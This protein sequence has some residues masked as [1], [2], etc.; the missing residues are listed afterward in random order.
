VSLFEIIRKQLDA[1]VC[2]ANIPY[3]V[4][5]R[6]QGVFEILT[7][8]ALM[9]P[10]FPPF[11]GM[12]KINPSGLP[13]QWS[14]CA[15][16]KLNTVRF[17][18][19]SGL[20]GT[21]SQW[22]FKLSMQKFEEVC[23]LLNIQFP[24]WLKEDVLPYIIPKND[25]W[26]T[27][28]LSAI[29]FAVGAS[30]NGILVKVYF[31]LLRDQAIDRWKRIGW[32]LKALGRVESL[33][34]LCNISGK[35][36]KD[37]WPSGLAIDILPNGKAGRVKIYFQS[38]KVFHNWLEKWYN[39]V[40]AGREIPYVRRMLEVY[41]WNENHPYMEK[42]FFTA[43][44][45][46]AKDEISLK[47]DLAVSRWVKGDLCIVEG[48][49]KLLNYLDLDE[50]HY[51]SWLKTIGAWPSDPSRSISHHLVGLGFEPDGAHHLNVYCE[52]PLR[53]GS[54]DASQKLQISSLNALT[55]RS[56]YTQS[57]TSDLE[58]QVNGTKSIMYGH[59]DIISL[60]DDEYASKYENFYLYPWIDKHNLNIKNIKLILIELPQENKKWLDICCGQA[61][62]FSMFPNT[63]EKVGVDIS[64]AQ[65]NLAINRNPDAVFIH[66][67]ILKIAFPEESF[68]VVTNFWAAY[69]YLNSFDRITTLVK[70]AAMW[71]KKG[72]SLY[73]EVL[74]PEDLKTFNSSLFA[75]KT[76]YSVSPRSSDFSKWSYQDAGGKHNMTSPP[77]EFFV[78]LLSEFF[79]KIETEHDS[80]FITHLIATDKQMSS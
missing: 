23:S 79:G 58:N 55:K 37:S 47:T 20:P 48:V 8:E 73:F 24:A 76:G 15:D 52:P 80:G 67:D 38:G 18:C 27:H 26:P 78:D 51:V 71:T 2:W 12:A 39:A 22:R 45:F 56:F 16:N 17:L 69:C 66:G 59:K 50:S 43:L 44:E 7:N 13:F 9:R 40:G 34:K 29:W 70:K 61:W 46:S 4:E 5:Q 64:E 36:S 21:S 49:R 72:G 30:S 77:I 41:P 53:S 63:I 62:H 10:A 60:Y 1:L 25:A 31:N 19:E 6:L 33:V 11:H 74:L 57:A 65:L 14:F 68:D 75:K 42:A 54:E 28:W 32:V 35:V 3:V